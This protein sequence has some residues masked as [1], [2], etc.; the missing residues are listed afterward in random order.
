MGIFT[1]A[2]C[3]HK[4]GRA[5]Q[6]DRSAPRKSIRVMMSASG[7]MAWLSFPHGSK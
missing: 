3:V 4:Y 2:K 5:E 6:Y 7:E 1:D